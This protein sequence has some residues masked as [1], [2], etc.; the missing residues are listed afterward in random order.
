[1]SYVCTWLHVV[2][3]FSCP[4][5]KKERLIERKEGARHVAGIRE[6][7]QECPKS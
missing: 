3:V 2:V 4:L 7:S 5:R 1:M 6:M